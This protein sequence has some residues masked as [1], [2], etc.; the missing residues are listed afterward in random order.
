MTVKLTLEFDSINEMRA[1]LDRQSTDDFVPATG[2]ALT[3]QEAPRR[4]RGRPRKVVHD[5][6]APVTVQPS[7]TE[8]VATAAVEPAEPA[9]PVNADVPEAPVAA[10]TVTADEAKA[11]LEAVFVKFGFPEAQKLLLAVG[12]TKM[13]DVKEEQLADFAAKADY[14]LANNG[15]LPG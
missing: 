13:R 1:W 15:K 7:V 11:K 12:A 8:P 5:N 10:A 14:M 4:P 6:T 3:P 9:S 2:D